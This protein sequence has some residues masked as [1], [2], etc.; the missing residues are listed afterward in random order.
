MYDRFGY[1]HKLQ[2]W[3][4]GRKAA[5]DNDSLSD[6]GIKSDCSVMFLYLRAAPP[7]SIP[8]VSNPVAGT[9][10]GSIV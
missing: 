9:F 4:I 3:I 8:A 6:C 2:K 10:D 1:S 5:S 7:G